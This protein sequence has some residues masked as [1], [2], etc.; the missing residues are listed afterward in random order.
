MVYCL[1]GYLLRCHK[2]FIPWKKIVKRKTKNKY[3][4]INKVYRIKTC[5]PDTSQK[6]ISTDMLFIQRLRD[7]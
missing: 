4:F 7:D 1:R 5:M 2:T 6:L 3:F